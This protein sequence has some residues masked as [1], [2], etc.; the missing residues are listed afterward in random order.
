L[1]AGIL[2][3]AIGSSF[4]L[5]THNIGLIFTLYPV[6]V[7][8]VITGLSVNPNPFLII[9]MSIN[10]PPGPNTGS[11]TA[12]LSGVIVILSISLS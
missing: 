6:V 12:P 7:F 11:R 10:L 5:F 4:N 2:D 8:I 1:S 9:L 3:A